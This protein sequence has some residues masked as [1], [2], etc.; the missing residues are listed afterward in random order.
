MSQEGG[1]CEEG[2]AEGRAAREEEAARSVKLISITLK[3]V[4]VRQCVQE[5]SASVLVTNKEHGFVWQ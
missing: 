3:A 1:A 4:R 5:A 2:G